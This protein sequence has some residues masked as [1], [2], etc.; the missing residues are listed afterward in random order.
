MRFFRE[1]LTS[2]Y[3]GPLVLCIELLCV[4][5]M[6][7]SVDVEFLK[8]IDGI[9]VILTWVILLETRD[10]TR[11][12][13]PGNYASYCRCVDSR[14]ESNGNAK[15]KTTRKTATNFSAGSTLKPPIT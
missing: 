14:R 6:P 5:T 7:V 3:R 4:L 10:I 9:G 12:K 13:D 2:P 11:F 15:A 8:N 1:F